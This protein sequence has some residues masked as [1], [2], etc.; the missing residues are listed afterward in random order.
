MTRAVLA[1]VALA[2]ACARSAP[3]VP[4]ADGPRPGTDAGTHITLERGPCFGTC[5]VYLVTVDGSGSVLFQGKRFVAD[6]GVS[7]ATVPPGR[8]DSLVAELAAGGYFEFAD[9]YVPGEPGC[10]ELVTTDLPSVT[11]E[12]QARGRRKR[13]EH[14]HGCPDAPPA[15]R[16]LEERIDEVAGVARWISR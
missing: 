15:L 14:Y 7:T 2:T 1:M 4:Q 9:R 13:I 16:G 11:T 12:V 5:P 10:G 8:V 3:P 6:S